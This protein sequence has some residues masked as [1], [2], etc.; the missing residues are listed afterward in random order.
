MRT[1]IEKINNN[2]NEINRLLNQSNNYKCDGDQY[3]RYTNENRKNFIRRFISF[4]IASSIMIGVGTW[5]LKETKRESIKGKYLKTTE[6]YSTITDETTTE[7]NEILSYYEPSNDTIVMV[8]NP[9]E[10]ESKRGYQY[11]DVS[12]LD[13][14]NPKDT[15]IM[16]SII[17]L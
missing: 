15:M 7:T 5:L 6:I 4:I 13:F 9:Y 14:D 17:M 1:I 8:Y 3:R 11:Y 16:V 10:S 12:Y 2:N